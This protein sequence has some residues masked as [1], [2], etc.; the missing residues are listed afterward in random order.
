MVIDLGNTRQKIAVFDNDLMVF[1][2]V[3]RKEKTDIQWWQEVLEAYHPDKIALSSTVDLSD[4]IQSWVNAHKV[5]VAGSHLRYPF[6]I[7]Y[8]TPETLG[9]DR[10]AAVSAVYALYRG[11]NVLIMD[12]GSCITYDFLTGEGRYVGGNIAPGLQMRLKAM[13]D[14]TDHLPLVKLPSQVHWLGQTTEQALQAGSVTMAILETRGLIS[15]LKE[16]YGHLTTVLTGGDAELIKNHLPGQNF[17]HTDLILTG[18]NE[19]LKY[20]EV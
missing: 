18:L 19:I 6:I 8:K 2:D 10:L 5:I 4:S 3:R 11:K 9:Q 12:C 16:N 14:Y 20:N 13:H 17:L 15:Y 1:S 7:D